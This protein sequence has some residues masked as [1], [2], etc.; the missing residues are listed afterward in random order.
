MLWSRSEGACQ[1]A[2]GAAMN[3]LQGCVAGMCACRL[4]CYSYSSRLTGSVQLQLPPSLP[5]SGKEAQQWL[6][7][8]SQLPLDQLYC[9]DMSGFVRHAFT[10]AFLHLRLH[11]PFVEAIQ[12]TLCKVG[13][14]HTHTDA[15]ENPL[16]LYRDLHRRLVPC[17]GLVLTILCC[18]AHWLP[19]GRL[20]LPAPVP[21]ARPR[22]GR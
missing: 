2:G 15:L 9:C 19:V 18:P 10:L 22:T 6:L 8:D 13:R 11:T 17:C 12:Q 16:D 7:Q 5:H 1:V 3:T 4:T 21:P 20:R 14:S